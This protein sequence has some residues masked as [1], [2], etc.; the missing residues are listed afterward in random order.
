MS[1][2]PNVHAFKLFGIYHAYIATCIQSALHLPIY[3]QT[4]NIMKYFVIFRFNF[5]SGYKTYRRLKL[6]PSGLL[7]CWTFTLLTSHP[8]VNLIEQ[9]S[10]SLS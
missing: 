4:L 8:L 5:A 3:C 1:A 9:I 2:F 7:L 6:C 10:P